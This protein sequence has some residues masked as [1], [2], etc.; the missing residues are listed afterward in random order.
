MLKFGILGIGQCGGN[1]AEYGIT[2]GFKSI[3]INTAKVDLN[4]LKYI[5]SDNKLYLDG[6]NGAGRNRAIGKEAII[7]NAES[8]YNI[9][10]EKLND[11]DTVFVACGGGGGTGSGAI[12]IAIEI[13]LEMYNVVNVIYGFPDGF[14]SPSAKMNAYDCF[15]EISE[16][17]QLGSIFILDNEKGKLLNPNIPKFKIQQMVNKQLIDLLN[18]VNLLT[19]KTSY[20]NN[21]D[22]S[23]LLDILSTRGC[24][25]VSKA[26]FA[27][28]KTTKDNDI[29]LM[30]QE[31]W[32]K[33]YTPDYE[34]NN[35]VKAAILGKLK[36][37]Y[38]NKI[39]MEQ[40]FNGNIPYDIKDGLYT[41]RD[42]NITMYSVFSGLSFPQTRL[43]SMKSDVEKVQD[44][45]VKRLELSQNQKL[46]N[47]EWKI[48][49]PKLDS[50]VNKDK[51]MSLSEKLKKY[52]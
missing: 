10:K 4:L 28:T 49:S 46:Q 24:T 51:S 35:I 45:I 25:L 39:N 52:R 2:N 18:E 16:N 47:V 31:S 42:E 43:Q 14:E 38:S 9:C 29:S 3:A 17:P 22:E 37:N 27:H 21:F 11:C 40:I 7:A 20:T 1:V 33:M 34:L 6:Y 5:P 8:V 32:K 41:S 12:P 15:S 48:N 23:D 44:D 19:E 30:I 13:L 36:N 26:E 50:P